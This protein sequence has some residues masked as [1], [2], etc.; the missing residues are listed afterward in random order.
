[1]Q[2]ISLRIRPIGDF[3]FRQLHG[4][5]GK[6][7]LHCDHVSLFM[8]HFLSQQLAQHARDTGMVSRRPDPCPV[9][10]GIIQSY[11]YISHLVSASLLK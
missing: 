9:G 2:R 10:D 11:R 3:C 7:F 5:N 6:K 4:C 1:M 8:R